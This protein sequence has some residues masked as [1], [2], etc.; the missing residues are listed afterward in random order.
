MVGL[1]GDEL[2][3]FVCGSVGYG[4]KGEILRL[5]EVLREAGYSVVDQFEEADYSNISDFRGD[6][7]LCRR[8]ALMDLEKCRDADVVVLIATRP[9]FGATVEALLSSLR[10]KPVIAYCPGEVRSPWPLYI[11]R[12][13]AR[14]VEELI[15]LLESLRG[16]RAGL[17]TIPNMQGEHEATFTYGDFSC[18]CPVTGMLDRAT[19]KVRYSPRSRL[20]EY[21]SLKDYF[22]TFRGKP[23][24]HEEVVATILRDIVR[25]AEPEL[26]EVEAVFE[27]RSGV[28]AR[29]AKTWRKGA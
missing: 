9:S 12:Y 24:H 1:L 21:E 14:T 5:Q 10:G 28:K 27:E 6:E 29:V 15:L 26:V 11:A 2:K 16:K 3:V 20:I 19:I 4:G 22:E 18:I 23:M 13:T 17:R 8:I 25:A 7:E